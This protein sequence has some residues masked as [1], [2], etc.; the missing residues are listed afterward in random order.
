MAY[1][2]TFS[3]FKGGAG[4]TTTCVNVACQLAEAGMKVAIVDLD[5]DGPG[6]ATLMDLSEEMV[7][8]RNIAR[9]FRDAH[10]TNNSNWLIDHSPRMS[11]EAIAKGG[12]L[13]VYAS[14][15]VPEEDDVLNMTGDD[16][17]DAFGKIITNM[18]NDY[19]YIFIDAASGIS[20]A[21]VLALAASDYIVICFR[22]SRQHVKGTF[23]TIK[24]AASMINSG[25]NFP[26]KN[27]FLVSN[28]VPKP[29]SGE[30]SEIAEDAKLALSAAVSKILPNLRVPKI[31]DL[32]ETRSL[33]FYEEILTHENNTVTQAEAAERSE[34][35]EMYTMLS[36]H[37]RDFIIHD[38]A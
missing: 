12:L 38:N 6:V 34:A 26:L 27:F 5:I 25:S 17:P 23:S 21:S 30:E 20:D 15:L 36:K 3:S 19:E 22:W 10:G 9:Y 14:P 35:L 8:T 24:L 7:H 4:R 2:I 33:R 1:I 18:Q 16:L 13:H 29:E 37:L 31:F 28:A 11:S 32:Y